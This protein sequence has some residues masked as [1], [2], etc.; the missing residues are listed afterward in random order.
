MTA[1][2]NQPILLG[3]R[4]VGRRDVGDDR[5]LS[6]RMM[7]LGYFDVFI[8]GGD[9]LYFCEQPLLGLLASVRLVVSV[10]ERGELGEVLTGG[11]EEQKVSIQSQRNSV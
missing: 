3:C 10:A 9:L 1:D 11:E 5:V 4:L 7:E 6:P 2:D 8:A